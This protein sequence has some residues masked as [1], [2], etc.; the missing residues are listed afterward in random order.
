MSVEPRITGDR[1]NI[2][3]EYGGFRHIAAHPVGGGGSVLVTF[4]ASG[5]SVMANITHAE[6]GALGAHLVRLAAEAEA[7]V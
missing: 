4:D 2:T 1:L 5:V 7:S 3:A 6:A